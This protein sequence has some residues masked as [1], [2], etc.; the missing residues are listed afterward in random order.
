MAATASG[1]LVWARP[2]MVAA[3]FPRRGGDAR[4]RRLQGRKLIFGL[5]DDG[6]GG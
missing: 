1:R 2:S 4:Y 5:G 3:M 6:L